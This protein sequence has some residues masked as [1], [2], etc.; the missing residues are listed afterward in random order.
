MKTI[1]FCSCLC[2][3]WHKFKAAGKHTLSIKKKE[4]YCGIYCWTTVWTPWKTKCSHF[5]EGDLGG[6]THKASQKGISAMRSGVCG[7]V[8]VKVAFLWCGV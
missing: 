8:C 1:A 7:E 2:R 5:Y 6:E 4:I 3:Q